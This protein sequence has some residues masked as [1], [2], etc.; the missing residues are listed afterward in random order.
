MTDLFTQAS[1][2]L[3]Q[4]LRPFTYDQLLGQDKLVTQIRN[5]IK[6]AVH[7]MV[8]YGPPGCGKTTLAGLIARETG[9]PADFLSAVSCGIKEVRSVIEQSRTSGRRILFLDEIH[10]FNKAQQDALLEAV[11]TGS[12]I[13]IGATT[14]NPSFSVI[15]PL[16]SRCQV[17]RL[18]SLDQDS[19]A[20]ILKNAVSKINEL[21]LFSSKISISAKAGSMLTEAAAGDARKLLQLFEIAVHEQLA[22]NTNPEAALE[23]SEEIIGPVLEGKVRFYDRAGENHYDFISAFIKSMRGS[24]PDAAVLYL[25]C[26]IEAGEDPLFIARRMIIFAS[27]DIGNASVQALSVAVSCYH[28]VEKIGMPEGRIVL[29]Q[30]AIF[31][32]C[33]PKSNASYLAIDSAL[34]EIKGKRITIPAHLRNAPTETHRQEGAGKGYLYPHNFSGHFVA[35]NYHPPETG[36]KQFYFPSGQGQEYRIR[37]K[38]RELDDRKKYTSD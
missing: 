9:L 31:L 33:S 10:R 19:L 21:S 24:D 5:R 26:M 7:S 28:A 11:E 2:P 8:L 27:E 3:A 35:Q 38:L 25:A 36:M 6:S 37:E 12:V 29:A 16:L 23:L 4:K 17:Y 13:L 34:E 15:S 22:G 1:E 14:E 18:T 20:E 30:T 32:A